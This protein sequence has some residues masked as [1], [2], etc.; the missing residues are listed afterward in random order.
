[1]S[2]IDRVGN[3]NGLE[4]LD[5]KLRLSVEQNLL[6]RDAGKQDIQDLA[7]ARTRVREGV[8]PVVMGEPRSRGARL[9]E[10]AFNLC[11]AV[12]CLAAA[13]VYV[14]SILALVGAG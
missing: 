14:R 1:M 11:V 5:P 7:L 12:L 9:F 3:G 10:L 6:H 8:Q 4:P 2:P 13:Y